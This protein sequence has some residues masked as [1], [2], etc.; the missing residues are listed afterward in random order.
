MFFA[1]LY[2]C[3]TGLMLTENEVSDVA[4]NEFTGLRIGVKITNM[5]PKE[6]YNRVTINRCSFQECSLGLSIDEEHYGGET[7]DRE[8]IKRS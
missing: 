1:R 2:H 4:H 8:V 7:E 5:L 6:F 3:T